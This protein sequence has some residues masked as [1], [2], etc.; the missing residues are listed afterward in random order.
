M[1]RVCSQR[2]ANILHSLE[3][4]ESVYQRLQV[5]QCVSGLQVSLANVV[6]VSSL[7]LPLSGRDDTG[8][9]L[10]RQRVLKP[11]VR[12]EWWIKVVFL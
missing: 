12:C 7:R 8:V 1:S 4:K 3:E 10:R 2:G 6:S 11:K 5:A 9:L